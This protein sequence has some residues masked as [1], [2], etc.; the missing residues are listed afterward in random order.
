MVSLFIN[1]QIKVAVKGNLLFPTGTATWENITTTAI[2]AYESEGKK[3]V[4]FN[5]GVSVKID[6]IKHLFVMPELYYSTFKNELTDPISNT[7]I[8]AKNNRVDVPILVGLNVLGDNLGIFVGPIASYNLSSEN[9]YNDFVENAK[10]KFT[11]GYQFG[12]QFKIQNLIFS[13]RYE[14]SIT[15]D[16]R[17]F[18]NDRTNQLIRYDNRPSLFLAG[19]G[20]KF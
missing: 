16:K 9:Q 3:N 11:V 14:G 12:A 4:G 6:L 1:S 8:V 2:N 19:I 17:E 20:Y 15:E 10:N 5:A 7:S 18:I 13:G